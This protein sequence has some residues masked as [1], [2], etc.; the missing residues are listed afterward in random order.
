MGARVHHVKKIVK[1][2]VLLFPD[3][4]TFPGLAN[5]QIASGVFTVG[6]AAVLP[7][8]ALMVLAPKAD[9]VCFFQAREN[10]DFM[11]TL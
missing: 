7:F 1:D 5:P 6:T 4:L 11:S 8:Y 10:M 9:L 3:I 2:S